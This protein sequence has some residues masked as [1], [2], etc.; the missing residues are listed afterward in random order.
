MLCS[1]IFIRDHGEKKLQGT[2]LIKSSGLVVSN[3]SPLWWK[4]VT[5]T[6]CSCVRNVL[7][8]FTNPWEYTWSLETTWNKCCV[9]FVLLGVK[10]NVTIIMVCFH[11][12]LKSKKQTNKQTKR[13]LMFML[14]ST[15]VLSFQGLFTC[16][17]QWKENTS[18]ML[19]NSWEITTRWTWFWA[20]LR[21]T[22]QFGRHVASGILN[23]TA[24][25]GYSLQSS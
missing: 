16:T 20:Q 18:A 6:S 1:I 24:I 4:C 25:S 21:Y 3:D 22:K 19:Q 14:D 23:R 5:A 9:V 17:L 10:R 15:L 11:L 12:S 2:A 7:L 8:S 13:V